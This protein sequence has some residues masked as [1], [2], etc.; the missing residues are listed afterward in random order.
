MKHLL[1]AITASSLISAPAVAQAP[2]PDAPECH[3]I[4]V[5]VKD[6]VIDPPYFNGTTWTPYT[7]DEATWPSV[8]RR[9]PGSYKLTAQRNKCPFVVMVASVRR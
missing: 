1:I 5:C 3:Y 9:Y 2:T 7:I 8:L 6:G 4:Q